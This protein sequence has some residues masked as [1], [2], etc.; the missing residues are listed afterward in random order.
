MVYSKHISCMTSGVKSSFEMQSD[1]R[2]KQNKRGK[3]IL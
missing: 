1:L 2:E 3:H